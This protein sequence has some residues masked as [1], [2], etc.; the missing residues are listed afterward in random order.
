MNNDLTHEL[1]QLKQEVQELPKM[2]RSRLDS[3]YQ[4]LEE[5][6]HLNQKKQSVRK[7]RRFAGILAATAA[8]TLLIIGSGF[9]S[10]VMA[11]TL[12]NIPVVGS[13]FIKAGDEGLKKASKQGLTTHANQSVTHEGTTLSISE[14]LYDGSRISMVLTRETSDGKN[15]TFRDW[16]D[17]IDDKNQASYIRFFVDDKELNVGYTM[18]YTGEDAKNSTIITLSPDSLPDEFKWNVVIWD[19]KTEQ[20]F[21]LIIPVKKNTT[22]NVI[23]KPEELKSHDNINMTI[24]KLEITPATMRLELTITGKPGQDIKE[25]EEAIPSQ[26]K[27]MGSIDINYDVM[28]DK[29]ELAGSIGGN[30]YGSDGIYEY[31]FMFEPFRALPQSITIK[32]YVQKGEQKEYIPELEFQLSVPK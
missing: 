5:G 8:S 16:W 9:I 27:I 3:T 26:Y 25:I 17:H 30:G 7:K 1:E 2:I 31:T 22:N 10:P 29:G 15:E 13:L 4:S 12:K 23:L 21:K 6:S 28:N 32:P 19:I 11:E 20:Q 18:S 24:K 14:L